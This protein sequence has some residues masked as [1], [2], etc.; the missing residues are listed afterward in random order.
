MIPFSSE[1]P[2]LLDLESH[3]G[4]SGQVEYAQLV[5]MVKDACGIFALMV[6]RSDLPVDVRDG[7]LQC[8]QRDLAPDPLRVLHLTHDSYDAPSLIAQAASALGGTGVIAVVGMEE[9]PGIIAGGDAPI[10]PPTLALLNHG[11]E[12]L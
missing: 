4:E 7:L 6:V 11:R 10:R 1:S 9:T 3:L 2:A 8:L 5:S 12:S